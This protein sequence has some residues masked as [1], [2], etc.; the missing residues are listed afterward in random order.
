MRLVT[1]ETTIGLFLALLVA[2]GASMPVHTYAQPQAPAL[3]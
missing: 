3:Y 1:S 2:G